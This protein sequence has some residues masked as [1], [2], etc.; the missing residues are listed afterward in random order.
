[1]NTHQLNIMAG[2]CPDMQKHF[3]GVFA[4]DSLPLEISHK[5]VSLIANLDTSM[6]DGSHWV[7]FYFP[8]H[9]LPEYM[10][11]F[12]LHPIPS[13]LKLL[14]HKYRCNTSFLQSP[15]SAVCGQ[16]CLYYLHRRG[17]TSSMDSVL[18]P[19]DVD[20][21]GFNDLYVNKYVEDHFSVDLPLFDI[22]WQSHQICKTFGC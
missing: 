20:D 7:C 11:S 10:D 22:K 17:L 13:F 19:F 18:H 5:P 2:S 4:S 9:G 15:F 6:E 14:G 12:G 1:M 16:Y 3:I 8:Q 21:R